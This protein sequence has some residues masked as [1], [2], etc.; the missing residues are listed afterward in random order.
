MFIA[1]E[2]GAKALVSEMID[3]VKSIENLA[4]ER[5]KSADLDAK[6]ILQTA[7]GEAEK[8]V[9]FSIEEARKAAEMRIAFAERTAAESLEKNLNSAEIKV[10]KLHEAVEKRKKLAR[11]SVIELVMN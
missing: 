1:G 2:R 7:N 9:N 10:K 11:Q 4:L 8:M 6:K 5:Q 3:A